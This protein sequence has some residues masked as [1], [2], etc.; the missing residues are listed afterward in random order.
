MDRVGVTDVMLDNEWKDEAGN[1]PAL[2][3]SFQT[4]IRLEQVNWAPVAARLK[5][6]YRSRDG[7]HRQ[8]LLAQLSDSGDKRVG[9][10]ISLLE[11][12]GILNVEEI[13]GNADQKSARSA[14]LRPKWMAG[15]PSVTYFQ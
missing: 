7:V 8:E 5:H 13:A 15:N 12:D 9:K 14:V 2:C 6:L 1:V 11:C 10:L 3:L 4:A